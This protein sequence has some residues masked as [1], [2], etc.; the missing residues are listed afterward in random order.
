MSQG[1]AAE[2]RVTGRVEMLG[3]FVRHAATVN[4][5]LG[6]GFDAHAGF[7]VLI[8][9]DEDAMSALRAGQAGHW[10]LYEVKGVLKLGSAA[11]ATAGLAATAAAELGL[12]SSTG[13]A[14]F[15]SGPVG[16]GLIVLGVTVLVLDGAILY[17]ESQEGPIHTLERDVNAAISR[18]FRQDVGLESWAPGEDRPAAGQRCLTKVQL[19]TLHDRMGRA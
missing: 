11:A 3:T 4:T 10:L 18:E 9:D 1:I 5:I 7:K 14:A 13:A 17:V 16:W 19:A 8:G 2:A 15:V 6:I 12:V